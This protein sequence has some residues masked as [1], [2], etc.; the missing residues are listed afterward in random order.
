MDPNYDRESITAAYRSN[1]G[2]G[3]VAQKGMNYLGPL[4]LSVPAFCSSAE[5][6]Q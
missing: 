4:P 2:F 6:R 1:L 3:F 5:P